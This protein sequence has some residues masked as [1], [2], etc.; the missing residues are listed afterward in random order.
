M[1]ST[2]ASSTIVVLDRWNCCNAADHLRLW[3]VLC[4]HLILVESYSQGLFIYF[5]VKKLYSQGCILIGID[6]A[7]FLVE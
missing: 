3:L 2:D 5:L 4:P 7:F 6:Y 1:E